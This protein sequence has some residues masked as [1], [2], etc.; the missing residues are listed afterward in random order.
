MRFLLF[1]LCLSVFPLSAQ[2]ATPDEHLGRTVGGDGTLADWN[3]VASY[4]EL[5]G[6]ALATSRVEIVGETTEGRKFLL[7]VISSSDNLERL[8]DILRASARIADPDGLDPTERAEVLSHA[9][10]IL[11][12][13]LGMH[14]TETS[15]PQFGMEL[16]HRLATSTEEPYASA[17]EHVVTVIAPCLNP[18]GLDHVVGWYRSVVGTPF[19]SASLP[20]LYQL[21]SGH[22]NN[23]DWFALSQKE[24]RIVTRE[25]YHRWFPHVYWDAHE[26]GKTRERFFVP[27]FRDPLNPNVSPH[28]VTGIDELGTRALFDMTREGFTGISTGVTYDMWWN[29]GNRNVPARHRIIGLLTEAASVYFGTPI[30]LPKSKLSAPRGIGSYAPSNRFPVPWPGG[31]WRMR[32]IIDYQHAF[33]RSLLA[34]LARE[35]ETWLENAMAAA[36]LDRK[37]AREGFPKGWIVPAT[38]RDR[39]AVERLVDI[40]LLSGIEIGR[41]QTPFVADG[42]HWPAGSLVLPRDQPYG[43]YLKDLFEAQVYP[44]GDEPY[45]VSGWTLPL[46]FGIPRVAYVELGALETDDIDSAKAAVEHF[47]TPARFSANRLD[48]QDSNTWKTIIQLLV[49]GGSAQLLLNPGGVVETDLGESE[50][51][52]RVDGMPRIGVVAPWQGVINEGWLRWMLE[53]Y[54]LPYTSVRFE[55]LRAGQLSD[56]F[57]VLVV[58]SLSATALD[59]GRKAGTAPER[60]VGGLGADGRSAILDFVRE[61]G[62]LITLERSSRWA[63]DL[64]GLPIE[65]V[66]EKAEDFA[67]PGSIVRAHPTRLRALTS[68]GPE[69]QYLF[70]SRSSAFKKTKPKDESIQS[71]LDYAKSQVLASGWIKGAKTIEGR[72]ALMRAKVGRGEIYLFGFRPQYRTWSHSAFL[73]L[74][75]AMIF[76]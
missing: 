71:H 54:E 73:L 1:L 16:A 8:D 68:G 76:G 47:V 13:S 2:V 46:L 20:K 49:R 62:R 36:D 33:S 45:D 50:P 67:C 38:T 57:D 70:F 64:F 17:R 42:R 32:D 4:H 22:D 53:S 52:G 35:P 34:S 30:F 72:S 3:E 25:L 19:E 44:E 24:S 28:V 10:P 48:S 26:Q 58:P 5:L 69:S 27:P 43:E 60:F 56:S 9:K 23:R 12:I 75:R 7:N 55:M 63:I 41:A 31:W 29:G 74:L 39:G 51:K 40:L 15:P 21:Y 61:G 14:S 65:D 6:D 11:F 37:K 66:T 59:D 18:D